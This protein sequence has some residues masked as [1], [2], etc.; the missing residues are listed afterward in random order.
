MLARVIQV[1]HGEVELAR[2]FA[3]RREVFVEEQRISKE[4]EFDG[5][6]AECT[7]F[8][9]WVDSGIDVS[10]ALGTARLWVDE[11]GI[12]KAQRVAVVSRARRTGVGR[13]L[14]RAVEMETQSRGIESLILGA[15]H[16]AIPF[17]ESIG[18]EVYGEEF[19]D[20]GIPHRMMRCK[21]L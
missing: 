5:L 18:Y 12:A 9:A 15:Q 6:D 2:C 10:C 20:A 17:Y 1:E 7:H 4:L 13:V 14:M 21:L 11:S 16:T 8:L 19:D 3:I